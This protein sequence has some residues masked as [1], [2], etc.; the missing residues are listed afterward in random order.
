MN[1]LELIDDT[2][3][4]NSSAFGRL[5]THYQ[6]RLYNTLV[7]VTGSADL[8]RDV[9]QDAFV[10]AFVKLSTF[11]RSSAFY[12]WLYRIALNMAASH[13][14]KRRP[15]ISV[16][17]QRE[18]SGYDPPSRDGQPSQPLESR[19]R[20]QR[21]REALAGLHDDFRT[22]LVLREI[23]GHPYEA[24][25]EMLDLPLGTVRSRL[26]RARMELREQL[27]GVLIEE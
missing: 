10:Q 17:Q 12:T 2:L 9:C 22:V 1:D 6:D 15:T 8:A 27:K 16:E 5:V 20:V 25:S 24:I 13:R 18:E 26:H 4:G 23:D 11:Q 3:R 21:V 14:R 19:E 7:H